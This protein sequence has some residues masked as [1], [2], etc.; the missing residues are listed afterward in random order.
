MELWIWSD[1]YCS[2][3][4]LLVHWPYPAQLISPGHILHA[5]IIYIYIFFCFYIHHVLHFLPHAA[6]L[7]GPGPPPSSQWECAPV[8]MMASVCGV[9]RQPGGGGGR[10]WR[11]WWWGG[12]IAALAPCILGLGVRAFVGT[13]PRLSRIASS[14][15][16]MTAAGARG[17]VWLGNFIWSVIPRGKGDCVRSWNPLWSLKAAGCIQFNYRKKVQKCDFHMRRGWLLAAIM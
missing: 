17:R 16:T 13:F 4:V 7:P 5:V 14:P 2:E 9:L 11:W 8:V 15:S 6:A 10:W 3:L 1:T 12:G